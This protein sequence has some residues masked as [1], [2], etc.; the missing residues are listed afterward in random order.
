MTFCSPTEIHC[1][2]ETAQYLRKVVHEIGLELK[3]SAVCTQVRRIRDGVFVLEDAL[4]R[5]QWKLPNILHAIWKSKLKVEAELQN[6]QAYRDFYAGSS[7]EEET[8][9]DKAGDETQRDSEG[10]HLIG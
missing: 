4:L 6:S 1:M 8:E 10:N 9:M 2:H 3:S 5:T 7:E